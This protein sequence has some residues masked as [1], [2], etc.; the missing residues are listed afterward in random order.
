MRNP[1]KKEPKGPNHP[2]LPASYT[3]IDVTNIQALQK[4]EASPEQQARALKWIIESACKTY[5]LPY[6]PGTEGQRDTDFAC[7]MQH[8][9]YTIVKMLKINPMALRESDNA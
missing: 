7:G 8:V 6:R 1:F 5:D 4:G 2:W 9:G 3:A